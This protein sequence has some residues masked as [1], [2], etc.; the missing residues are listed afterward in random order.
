MRRESQLV[1]PLMLHALVAL[2]P[3]AANRYLAH[4]QPFAGDSPLDA[5]AQPPGQNDRA[6]CESRELAADRLGRASGALLVHAD[7]ASGH[8]DRGLV[9]LQLTDDVTKRH[10]HDLLALACPV[11]PCPA[12]HLPSVDAQHLNAER[13]ADTRDQRSV[14]MDH[15]RLIGREAIRVGVEVSGD[16]PPAVAGSGPGGRAAR[17]S[18]CS[19]A[20]TATSRSSDQRVLLVAVLRWL[21]RMRCTAKDGTGHYPEAQTQRPRMAR[22]AYE[23]VPPGERQ[24]DGWVP[25][26]VFRRAWVALASCVG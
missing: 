6:R 4:R 12:Q 14:P 22:D 21:R 8:R 19:R 5:F 24:R 20:R 9:V 15:V 23:Q 7:R 2:D 25:A 18:E 11:G 17:G 16:Q 3:A 10:R 26:V 13:H 1:S